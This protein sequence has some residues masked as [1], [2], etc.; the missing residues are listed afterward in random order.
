M[1]NVKR[2]I[3]SWGLGVI[4]EISTKIAIASKFQW[5]VGRGGRKW[6]PQIDTVPNCTSSNKIEIL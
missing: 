1:K 2:Q 5:I 6:R 4:T 3:F